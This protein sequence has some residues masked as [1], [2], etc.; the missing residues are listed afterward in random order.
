MSNGVTAAPTNGRQPPN[1]GVEQRLAAIE[2]VLPTLATK[3]DLAELYRVIHR[4]CEWGD[5]AQRERWSRL[6]PNNDGMGRLY[7]APF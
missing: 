1:G 3:A 2:A 5:T 7:H 4:W 6:E